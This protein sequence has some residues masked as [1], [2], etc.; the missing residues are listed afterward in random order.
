[1]QHWV[2]VQL[3]INLATSTNKYVWTRGGNSIEDQIN[4]PLIFKFLQ[5]VFIHVFFKEWSDI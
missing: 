3:R 5:L 1:M 2:D 4:L